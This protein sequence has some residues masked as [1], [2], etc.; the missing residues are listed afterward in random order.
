MFEI[1]KLRTFII[2]IVSLLL[3]A[4]PIASAKANNGVPSDLDQIKALLQQV[5]TALTPPPPPAPQN[6]T[7]LLFAFASSEPGFDTGIAISNT[8]LDSTGTIG[9][10]G[11]ATIYFFPASGPAVPAFVTPVIPVGGL[12]AN[13]LSILR[14][15]FR[16]YIEVVTEFPFAHGFGLFSD[17]GIRNF[18]TTIPAL[19]LPLARTNTGA[20]SL[21]Q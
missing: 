15:N 1:S 21:G 7:R 3:L 20:E 8:G 9:I 2:S 12:Y 19:V 16:G 11:Q 6:K 17:T 5:L 10:A 18:A 4:S 14:P 13:Q